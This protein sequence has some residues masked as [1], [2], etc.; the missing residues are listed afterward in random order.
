MPPFRYTKK[1]R[2]RES[3]FFES[4]CLQIPF[5]RK[6][7]A[8]KA[9]IFWFSP[10]AMPHIS[11]SVTKQTNLGIYFRLICN[12]YAETKN[13]QIQKHRKSRFAKSLCQRAPPAKPPLL[14]ASIPRPGAIPH[15][16][17]PPAK[18]PLLTVS[19]PRPSPRAPHAAQN[20]I[21]PYPHSSQRAE[22]TSTQSPLRQRQG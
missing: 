7:I 22:L 13:K 3:R 14:T 1:I 8:N 16:E 11:F 4:L 5:T 12:L 9:Y 2:H 17:H 19:I 10:I 6:K 20:P 18:P 21:Q 15:N